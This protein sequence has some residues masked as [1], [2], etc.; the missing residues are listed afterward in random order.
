MATRNG[1]EHDAP[2][3]LVWAALWTVY[4]VWGSTYLAIRVTVET[5]PPLLAGGVRFLIAGAIVLGVIWIR[6][7][8]RAVR[9]SRAECSPAF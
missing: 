2:S 3:W 5:L 7:G 9:I 4:I 1:T 8:R 6:K